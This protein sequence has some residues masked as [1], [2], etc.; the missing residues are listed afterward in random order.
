MTTAAPKHKNR[1]IEY[2]RGV[3]VSLAIFTHLPVLLPY[4]NQPLTE[5][6]FTQA[7][8]A[9]GVQQLGP[10]QSRTCRR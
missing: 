5:F 1:E 4:F 6:F 7:M 3:A 9:S 8:P 2:L 10:V